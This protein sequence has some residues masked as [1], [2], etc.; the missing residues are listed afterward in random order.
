MPKKKQQGQD[1]LTPQELIAILD[2][3]FTRADPDETERRLREFF[4]SPEPR[5]EDLF[6]AEEDD[7]GNK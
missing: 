4:N 2:E 1:I 7:N 6:P 5:I 3:N